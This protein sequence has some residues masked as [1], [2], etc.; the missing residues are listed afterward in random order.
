MARFYDF[1][2]ALKDGL[3]QLVSQTLS[4]HRDAATRD[5]DAFL[6]KAKADLQRWTKALARGQLTKQDFAWLVEGKRDLAEMV[7]LKQAGLALVQMDKFR[8]SLLDLVI[9]TAFKTFL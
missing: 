4:D 2:N 7:A 5:S 8:N 1:L 3:E 9:D 6:R